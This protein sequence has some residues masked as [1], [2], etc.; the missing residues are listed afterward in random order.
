MQPT[1]SYGDF[2]QSVI[3]QYCPQYSRAE[4]NVLQGVNAI[5]Y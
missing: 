5:D 4:Q 2:L 1:A 3:T